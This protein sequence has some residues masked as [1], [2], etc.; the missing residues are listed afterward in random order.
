MYKRMIIARNREEKVPFVRCHDALLHVLKKYGLFFE[1]RIPLLIANAKNRKIAF[2][3]KK[4]EKQLHGMLNYGETYLFY[5]GGYAVQYDRNLPEISDN[6]DTLSPLE[7]KHSCT[8]NDI[9]IYYSREY[10]KQNFIQRM[11]FDFR[12]YIQGLWWKI[13]N[14]RPLIQYKNVTFFN[15]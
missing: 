12:L 3:I 5:N 13:R 6:L 9:H 1:D 4:D 15:E 11:W 8:V 7:W 10:R 14:Y 2:V